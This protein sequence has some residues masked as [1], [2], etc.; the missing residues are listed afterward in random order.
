MVQKSSGYPCPP[1]IPW[2]VGLLEGAAPF[3]A[4]PFFFLRDDPPYP[5]ISKDEDTLF[6]VNC[7]LGFSLILP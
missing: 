2:I 4:L 3:N 7:H 6:L 1:E 5:Q